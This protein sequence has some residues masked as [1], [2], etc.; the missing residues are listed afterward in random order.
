[1]QGS[2]PSKGFV[3]VV[4]WCVVALVALTLA[5][6]LGDAG[7]R[8]RAEGERGP[9]SVL[10]RVRP[11]TIAWELPF[12]A[13][14]VFLGTWCA[15]GL[16]HGGEDA[17]SAACAATVVA[18]ACVLPRNRLAGLLALWAHPDASAGEGMHAASRGAGRGGVRRGARVAHALLHVAL[19]AACVELARVALEMPW[20][21]DWESIELSYVAI[22]ATIIALVLLVLYFA[23]NQHGVGVAAGVVAMLVIGIANYFVFLFKDAAITP[24]DLMAL[25]TAAEVA[26][27]YVYVIDEAVVGA[28]ARACAGVACAAYLLPL[29]GRS[30]AAEAAVGPVAARRGLRRAGVMAAGAAVS[31]VALACFVAIPSYGADFGVGLDHWKPMRTASRQGFWPCFVKEVQVMQVPVPEGYSADAVAQAKERLR[32]S[33]EASEDATG[34]AAAEAQFSSLRPSVV[35]IMNESYSDL[36]SIADIAGAGYEGPAWLHGGLTDALAMGDCYTTIFGGGTCNTEFEA[37]TDVNLHFV[38]Q[39]VYPYTQNDLERV[40]CLPR[41]FKAQGYDTTAIHPNLATNWNRSASYEQMGF[42]RFLDIDDFAGASLYH[43]Y[44][45]D[46]ATYDKI[47]EVLRADDDPQFVLDVTMQNHSPYTTGTIPAEDQLAYSPADCDGDDGNAQLNEYL[48][49][50]NESDRAI[51]D[52]IA[53][54]RELDR[55]VVVLFFGDHQPSLSAA[56]NDASYPADSDVVH[57]ERIFHTSYFVW[58]NYDVAGREQA[59]AT[60]E[61]SAAALGAVACDLVGAPLTDLQ[62]STLGSRATIRA[63]NLDGYEDA[64]GTWHP[65]D[66]DGNA[67]GDEA[68]AEHDLALVTYATY[69][70]AVK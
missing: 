24:A 38:G 6:A 18:G 28:V 4:V 19:L 37:L 15:R 31:A 30:R 14:L 62:V 68:Q 2:Y 39:Y 21:A 57:A 8:A 49:C 10:R 23:G 36:S 16:Y 3:G 20:N 55:P 12:L 29:E 52:F 27:A 50:V 7:L 53:E 47:L 48:A 25:G 32:A 43:G 56:Y 9:A 40:E 45:S 46:A 51:E 59:S 54:L 13:A 60:R 5:W 44:T 35:V 63:L 41:S 26:G 42:D 70:E 65:Y 22:E 69:G 67:T 11:S 66:E 61:E 34:R 1:M 58:A 17:L 64:S 33:Y